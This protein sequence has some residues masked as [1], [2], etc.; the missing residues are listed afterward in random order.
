M[1]F[2]T[3]LKISPTS[4]PPAG[5]WGG[6]TAEERNKQRPALTAIVPVANG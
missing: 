4:N 6:R 3:L 5:I 2:Q 1:S